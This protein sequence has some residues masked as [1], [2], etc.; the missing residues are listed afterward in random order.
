MSC[1][2]FLEKDL[3]I[4]KNL[5][6]PSEFGRVILLCNFA[7][8]CHVLFQLSVAS[9]IIMILIKTLCWVSFNLILEIDFLFLNSK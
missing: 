1:D 8:Y 2:I 6:Q 3:R 7:V 5:I 4:F 9:I